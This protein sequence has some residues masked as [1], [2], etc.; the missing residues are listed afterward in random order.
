MSIIP[1][2]HSF[3]RGSLNRPKVS[4]Q[5]GRVVCLRDFFVVAS[6][7]SCW[8]DHASPHLQC[9]GQTHLQ[10]HFKHELLKSTCLL[11]LLNHLDVPTLTYSDIS[12]VKVV[13]PF[14]LE[15]FFYFEIEKNIGS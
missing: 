9:S 1:I 6:K 10:M 4:K 11:T 8:Q 7:N 5:V 2:F 15:F 3:L 13:F 14:E 12:L